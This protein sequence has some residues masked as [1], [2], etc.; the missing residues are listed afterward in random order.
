MYFI[1]TKRMLEVCFSAHPN[2]QYRTFL[3]CRYVIIRIYNFEL[4]LYGERKIKDDSK[5]MDRYDYT[6]DAFFG[7]LNM[8]SICRNLETRN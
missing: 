6:F 2:I 8:G 7:H 1:T 3:F 4:P 5:K